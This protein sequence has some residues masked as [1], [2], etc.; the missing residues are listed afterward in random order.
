MRKKHLTGKPSAS[1]PPNPHFFVR[2][3]PPPLLVTPD[4]TSDIGMSGF[5]GDR[6]T[7]TTRILLVDDDLAVLRSLEAILAQSGFQVSA[8]ASVPEALELIGKQQFE[9]LLTDMNIGEP[10][11]GFTV[12]GAMRRVQPDASAFILT[13]YPDIESAIKAVRSQVDDY[14]AKPLNIDDLLSAIAEARDGRKRRPKTIQA[15]R[16]PELLR[17]HVRDVCE[18]WYQEVL[19]D[20]ELAAIPL[21]KEERT[22]HLPD[23]LQDLIRRL[24]RNSDEWGPGPAESARKHGRARHQQGYTIPQILL[25]TRI[26]QKVISSMIQENLLA[27]ELSTL[28]PDILEIG[29]S[30]Q[31]E[32]EMSIRA[33]Q[34]QIPASLQTSFSLLYRSPY[35]GVAIVDEHHIIDANAALLKMIGYTREQLMRGEIDW[36]K[37]TPEKFRPLDEASIE[38]LREFG[39]CAPFEKEFVLADG[40]ELP[41]LIG[42]I[43]L[44]T[45]PLQWSA[46]VVNMTEQRKLQA[47][48]QT[49]REWESRNVLINR[50]AHEVNNPLAGL[51]FT[52]HLLKTYPNLS[53]DMVR[54]IDDAIEMLDRITGTVRKVLIESQK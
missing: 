26:L 3:G 30:L 13:G 25:E 22:D 21:T 23:L 37:M 19:R 49:V 50:L 20:P 38:Q 34:A 31:A 44:T 2:R 18:R 52:T 48:E 36:V 39:V 53:E 45:E 51:V 14:F 40:T 47:A 32:V 11:D 7:G 1:L 35:L 6:P 12:V 29:Y 10:G 16:M 33:Y 42:A 54:L 43:R 4:C 46:Y 27:I 15:R 28:V 24:E 9:V 8:V 5:D 41:F 17:D